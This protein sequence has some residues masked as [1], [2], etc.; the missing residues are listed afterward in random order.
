V[1]TVGAVSRVDLVSPPLWSALNGPA[2]ALP[3]LAAVLEG[4]YTVR[5]RDLNIET[6]SSLEFLD[7]VRTGIE[8]EFAALDRLET[9]P[10]DKI[11]RYR[12]LQKLISRLCLVDG[13]EDDFEDR[14]NFLAAALEPYLDML[15]DIAALDRLVRDETRNPFLPFLEKA[16]LPGHLSDPPDVVGLSVA[17]PEQFLA[18]LTIAHTVLEHTPDTPVVMGGSLLCLLDEEMLG[19]ILALP[20]VDAIIR[21][22]GEKPF[23]ALLE[24]I[25]GDRRPETVPNLAWIEDGT[26]RCTEVVDPLPP[27]ECPDPVFAGLPEHLYARPVRAP[28]LQARGCYWGRCQFCDIHLYIGGSKGYLQRS[29]AALAGLMRTLSDRHGFDRFELVTTAMSPAYARRFSQALLDDETSVRWETRIKVEKQFDAPLLELMARAGC[30]QI[31]IG[32][33][34]IVPRVIRLMD[35]GN[36]DRAGVE[37]LLR[38]IHD[39]GI[40]RTKVW[41]LPG[42]PTMT[43]EE[44]CEHVDFVETNADLI[45]IMH[46]FPFHVL[47][48]TPMEREPDRFGLRLEGG[49]ERSS[50]GLYSLPFETTEGMSREEGERAVRKC[51]DAWEAS[52]RKEDEAPPV[53]ADWFGAAYRLEERFRNFR[54]SHP[55]L[56]EEILPADC[57]STCLLIVPGIKRSYLVDGAV[58][59]ILELLSDGSTHPFDAI[60]EAVGRTAEISGLEASMKTIG[61]LNTL[62]E[63]RI[64]GFEEVRS[65]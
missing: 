17:C 22:E 45:S 40:H 11:A 18:A 23:P 13:G 21:F 46:I 58:E 51:I 35:K 49:K 59:P 38:D 19:R 64:L 53:P 42:F 48:N 1:K 29:P 12:D 27:D 3:S 9:I 56:L 25:G 54:I 47:A 8:E 7:A 62:T 52:H 34:S 57:S 44:A 55:G 10:L 28:V 24:A 37:R 6:V 60:S 36:Y 50:F 30:D 32:V 31:S 14:F 26:V 15:S 43:D 61:Y 2:L 65:T 41:L 39:A 33:E 5:Q 63:C 20:C 4:D 16:F